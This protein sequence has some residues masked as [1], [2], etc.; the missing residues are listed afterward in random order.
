MRSVEVTPL[1][2]APAIVAGVVNVG[3]RVLPVVDL[4]KRFGLPEREISLSDQLIVART[5]RRTVALIVDA[6]SDVVECSEQEISVAASII[7]GATIVE[8]V[9]R[10]KDGMVVIQ[11]LDRLLSLEEDRALDAALAESHAA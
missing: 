8:G 5:P 7:P 9:A 10:L 11:D 1:P 4:R 6:V 2:D 3:G